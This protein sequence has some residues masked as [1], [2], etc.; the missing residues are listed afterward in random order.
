VQ[1]HITTR[2]GGGVHVLW[3][4]SVG[5][6][7]TGLPDEISSDDILS[8]NLLCALPV[9]IG[10]GEIDEEKDFVSVEVGAYGNGTGF[11]D[12]ITGASVESVD[13]DLMR[14]DLY[15]AN[16]GGKPYSIMGMTAAPGAFHP[17]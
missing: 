12:E 9:E 2:Q 16:S 10:S 3:W 7:H 14:V 13:L 6:I 11:A 17:Y 8:W 1:L 5:H 15:R 4:R